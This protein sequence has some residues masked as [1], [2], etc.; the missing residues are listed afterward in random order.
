[1]PPPSYFIN[2]LEFNLNVQQVITG[3]MVVGTVSVEIVRVRVKVMGRVRVK[4]RVMIGSI[5]WG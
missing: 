3:I 2:F 4:F 1:M 5:I